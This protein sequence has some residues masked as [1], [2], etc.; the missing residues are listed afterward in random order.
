ML[1]QAAPALIRLPGETP[2]FLILL[3]SH[4]DSVT[5]LTPQGKQRRI[6]IDYVWQILIAPFST[7][8]QSKIQDFLRDAGIHSQRIEQV[9][10]ALLDEQLAEQRIANAWLLRLA[11]SAPLW[12]QL[13]QARIPAQLWKML[14]ATLLAQICLVL[15]WWVI[16]ESALAGHFNWANVSA[17][18]LLLFSVIPFQLW[19]VWL[20]SRLALHTG[21]LFKQRLLYGILQLRPE[22][23]R[24]QGS[25]Q[26]LSIVM[27][28][29][30]LEN[31]GVSGALAAAIASVEV[32]LAAVVLAFGLGGWPHTALLLLWMLFIGGL[33]WRYYRQSQT[34]IRSY[35][36]MSNDLLERMVG[37]RTRLA[38]E[39]PTSWHNDEDALLANYIELSAK[40]DR[41]VV[42]FR[43][44][45]ERGWLLLGVLGLAPF[46][47][48]A[49]TATAA[50][51]ISFGGI[52]LAYQALTRFTMGAFT[53]INVLNAWEQVKPLFDAARRDRQETP[54]RLIPPAEMANPRKPVIKASQLH[55]KYPRQKQPILRA[56]ELT[57]R[58]GDRVLLEGPSG[59]GKSTLAAILAG[60]READGGQLRLHGFSRAMLGS[61]NWRRHVVIAPQFHENHILSETFAFNLL[62]G[63]GWPPSQQDFNDAEQICHELGLGELLER[64]PAGLQQMVGESGW[65]LSH[66]ERSR[67]FIART[68][69]QNPDVII[70]DES[71]AAL[72]PATLRLT[73]QCVL[74]RAKTLLVIAHP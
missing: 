13:K 40:L 16:G 8:A 62:M 27:E 43:G 57:I 7:A 28:A 34:W 69:L 54:P 46:F 37:H 50:L 6:D 60:L 51:A 45:S 17:W 59:G 29:E 22:E 33:C 53:L 4:D 18:A 52:L 19:N 64:M 32:L 24:T 70:L 25:G 63:R 39:N 42:L 36:N 10:R 58:H 44:L 21:L 31:L 35:R 68:L 74:R 12:Q 30:A 56:A 72:D 9:S 55:F 2:H 20:E 47:I 1:S 41:L 66:G 73:L 11:P 15:S 3:T 26:F 38:Q 5:V 61:A 14:G 49:P 23:I 71:F 48:Q 67:L 65:Q